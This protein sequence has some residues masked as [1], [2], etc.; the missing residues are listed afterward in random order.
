MPSTH[1]PGRP[2]SI[3]RA[4]RLLL[5][6]LIALPGVASSATAAGP[7]AEL[8]LDA[9]VQLAAAGSRRA[10][11]AQAMALAAREAA[12]VA[13]ARPDPVLRAGVANL[14]IDG[15]DRFS[16]TRDFMTMRSLG[17][18]QE[19]TRA[20]KR[21]ARAERALREADAA[22]AAEQQA[23]ADAQRE[24]AL[25][26]LDR[27]FQQTALELL[28]AQ[29]AQAE[30]QVQAAEALYRG[31]RGTL[32][33]ALAARAQVEQLRD[34]ADQTERDAM[35]AAT[36]LERWIGA[37]AA[38]PTAARPAFTL[39]AWTDADLGH[40]LATH[41][42]IAAAA[43]QES[44]AL[45][46]AQVARTE[47]R[48]DWSVEVM[49]S[50]RGPAYSNMVSINF[51]LPLTWQREARQ[52]REVAARQALAA[53]SR[54][55]LDD[56][57]RAHEAEVR[58][59]LHEWRSHTTRLRRYDEQ[60]LPLAEQRTAASLSTYRGGGG[61]LAAVLEARRA[62][63]ELRLERLRLEA[64]V[65]RLWAQLAYLIPHSGGAMPHAAPRSQP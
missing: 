31:N 56:V 54:A 45:A 55:E 30:L 50:Q 42:Q 38:R 40:A 47:A 44:L 10:T 52:D 13:R 1:S 2:R 61:A 12:A 16:L 39:P 64:D 28:Q 25:A 6:A 41:P 63:V 15:P 46:D 49:F 43:R 19:L 22:G 3:H 57:Q 60:L 26:W 33:D 65:A 58:A 20:D 62:E 27:S 36:R 11:A 17:V 29:V 14:P 24:S 37:D 34:R 53:R 7:D 51:S 59:M 5:G 23:L 32:A 9:T 48:A 35:L 18:M 21:N 8:T 4:A